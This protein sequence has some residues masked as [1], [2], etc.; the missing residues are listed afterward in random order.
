MANLVKCSDCGKKVSINAHSCPKCGA[1]LSEQAGFHDAKQ[2]LIQKNEREQKRTEDNKKF[3]SQ[4]IAVI[5]GFFAFLVMF[6]SVF[7]GLIMFAGAVLIIP[8]VRKILAEKYLISSRALNWI[9]FILIAV[10]FFSGIGAIDTK[11]QEI[12]LE[13]NQEVANDM[14]IKDTEVYQS[15][16][17]DEGNQ[18]KP[19]AKDY[20]HVAYEITESGYPKTYA[21]WGR[22]WIDDINSMMPLAVQ[23][24]AENPRCDAPEAADLSDNRSSPKVEAVFYVDCSNGERF[25]VSQNELSNT[26]PIQAE[27]DV[28]SGQPS[29]YIKPC[30]EMVEAQLNYPS[31]FNANI[32]T[33]AFKGTSGNIVVEMSFTAKNALGAELPQAARCVFGTNGENEAVITNR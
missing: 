25:Y 23:R 21:R 14:S 11:E 10:G 6:S 30:Q 17:I 4:L 33:N 2:K 29:E 9:S 27:S 26:T 12:A 22:K 19:V 16:N 32:G 3:L 24:V 8:S 7:F 1:I 5:L 31:S 20:S 18:P 15:Q 13:D 28:L